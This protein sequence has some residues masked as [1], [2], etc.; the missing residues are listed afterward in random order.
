MHMVTGEAAF[1]GNLKNNTSCGRGRKNPSFPDPS[2]GVPFSA[3]ITESKPLK[4]SQGTEALPLNRLNPISRV[5]QTDLGGF[6]SSDAPIQRVD[7]IHST[8]PET[9]SEISLQ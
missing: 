8:L 2:L 3:N 7:Q 6:V 5:T 4:P 1:T 9:Y